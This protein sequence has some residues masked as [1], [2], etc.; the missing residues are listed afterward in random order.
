MNKD[1]TTQLRY[2]E[3][4]REELRA[5]QHEYYW[6]NREKRLVSCQASHRRKRLALIAIMG[7]KCVQCGFSDVRALQVDHPNGNGK[8]H[9]ASFKNLTIFYQYVREHPKEFVLLCA[10]C[11]FIKRVEDYKSH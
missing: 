1:N 3:N 2:R 6:S 11:N 5:R 4:H 7:G 9:R 10:N 8:K